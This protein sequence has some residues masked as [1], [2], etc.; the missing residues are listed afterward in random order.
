MGFVGNLPRSPAVK[1]FEN[2]LRIDNKVIAITLV[3]NFFWD[4]VYI[5]VATVSTTPQSLQLGHSYRNQ[6]Q[7]TTTRQNSTE[8]CHTM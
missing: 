3:Y 5:T 1:D 2:T 6:P 8:K 4:T 7:N